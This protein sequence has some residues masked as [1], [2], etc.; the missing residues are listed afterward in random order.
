MSI[1]ATVYTVVSM[2]LCTSLCAQNRPFQEDVKEYEVGA[3]DT[4]VLGKSKG[5]EV[6][7]YLDLYRKTRWDPADLVQDSFTLKYGAYDSATGNG[8]YRYF[9][10]GDFDVAELPNEFK[11]RKCE[12]LGVEVLK[13]KE[14]GEDINVMYLK[15]FQ[16]NTVIWVD[17]DDAVKYMEIERFIAKKRRK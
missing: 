17:F 10:R 7:A 15:G 14:T 5:A 4:A 1:K 2:F 16:E 12:I 9:F 6:Y 13:K 3:G 11:G 8:F